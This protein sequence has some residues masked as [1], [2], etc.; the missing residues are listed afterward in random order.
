MSSRPSNT[1]A[2]LNDTERLILLALAEGPQHGYALLTEV[3]ARSGGFV[4]PGPTSLYRAISSL[5]DE[6]LIEPA[7]SVKTP[8]DDPRRK[9]FRHTPRGKA[10]LRADLRRLSD[11]LA[12]ARGMGISFESGGR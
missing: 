3:A 8:N 2:P 5:L 4:A 10:V 7:R 12:Q 9:Y 1:P 6:G 11:L